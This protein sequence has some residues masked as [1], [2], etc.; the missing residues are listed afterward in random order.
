MWIFETSCKWF[1]LSIAAVKRYFMSSDV[2]WTIAV[3]AISSPE[4]MLQHASRTRTKARPVT[5]HASSVPTRRSLTALLLK[6]WT[7]VNAG[8]ASRALLVRPC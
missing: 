5:M 4:F 7:N 1:I 8:T 3:R 2:M 6:D